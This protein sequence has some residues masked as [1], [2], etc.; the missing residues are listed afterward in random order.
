MRFDR[1]PEP[2]DIFFENLGANDKTKVK[3]VMCASFISVII[4]VI[5]LS[6]NEIFYIIQLRIDE[7]K[8]QNNKKIILYLISFI[9]TIVTAIIDLIV[10]KVLEKIIKWEKT[11]TLTVFYVNYSKNLTVF[12]FL[13][14][15]LLPIV[16]DIILPSEEEHEVLTSNMLIKFLFNSFVTPIMWTIN[17]KFIYKKFKQCVIEQKENINYNQKELNELYELPSMDVA[18]KYSYLIKTLL[19]SSIFAA[20][21]PLGFCISFVGFIFGYW[22]EKFN[23]SKMYKK[24]EKLD[25]QINE[26]YVNHFIIIF[27]VMGLGTFYFLQGFRNIGNDKWILINFY[28]SLILLFMPFNMCFQKDFFNIKKSKIHEKT[29]DEMYLDFIIDYERANPM[30][31]IEGEMRYLYKLEENKRINKI[32]KD[33]RKKKINEENQM[34]YYIRQQRLSRIINIKELNNILN[35]NDN[36]EKEKEKDIIDNIDP[37]IENY[38]KKRNS[39]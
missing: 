31:R 30:T 1:A 14:S 32:E 36:D 35:L 23:F 29:Y 11:Y 21:F 28:F 6:I 18:V 9:I 22:L 12:W 38:K 19:M 5:S 37:M 3:K 15:S 39:I 25:K 13:N 10:E 33:K 16:G 17:F 4:S 24:P 26:S 7:S 20:I 34:K 27:N 2:E 8:E